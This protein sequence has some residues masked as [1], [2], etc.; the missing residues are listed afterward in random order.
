MTEYKKARDFL[1]RAQH[2]EPFNNDINNELKK[3]A[4]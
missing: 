3:L 2:I 4:R 1:V